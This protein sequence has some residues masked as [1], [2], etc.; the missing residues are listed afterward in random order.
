LAA[1]EFHIVA[2]VARIQEL[3]R[4]PRYQ[5]IL[6]VIDLGDDPKAA[7]AQIAEFKEHYRQGC[8]AV[9]ANRNRGSSEIGEAFRAGA[10]AYFVEGAVCDR[11][12][13]SLELVAAGETILPPAF[14]A[15]LLEPERGKEKRRLSRSG[16][17]HV[18]GHDESTPHLSAREKTIL[19]C[20]IEGNSNK[21]IA[22][23]CDI[24]EATVKVHVKTILRKI[25][26]NNRTK[27]AIWAINNEQAIWA[28]VERSANKLDIVASKP[29]AL[30][31]MKSMQ[32]WVGSK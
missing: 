19:R 22:R 2:S 6:L 31:S 23:E 17:T 5:S 11:F 4:W 25:G 21:A 1:T 20:L 10:N 18:N 3:N 28:E 27:A 7:F 12:I 29:E 32:S 16:D 26:V 9:L 15:S 14:L 8:V 13:K 24:A 30:G